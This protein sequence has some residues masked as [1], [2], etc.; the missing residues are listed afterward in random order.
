VS[1]PENI[2]LL[3]DD[4][5]Q[6]LGALCSEL[7][8]DGYTVIVAIDGASALERLELVSPDA[9]LMDAL[10]PG[11]D[12]FETCRR[13]KSDPA[14][15]HVPVIFM[16]GLSETS[17]IVKG[18]DAGGVDYVVKPVRAQ[19]VMVR[20]ATHVR[21]ARAVRMARESI[22]IGG[23]GMLMVDARQRLAWQSPQAV[24]WLADFLP[25]KSPED[26]MRWL[27][28]ASQ[29]EDE[30]MPIDKGDQ[31]LVAK[32]VGTVGLGEVMWLLSVRKSDAPAPSR[33]ASAA[34]TPREVEVLSWVS[35]GKTNRDVAEILGMS[36]RTVNKHLEHV[37]EKLGVETR[38]AAAA[39]ASI[40]FSSS[41]PPDK[42]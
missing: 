42:R 27:H 30:A 7:E 35:K 33:L 10:M 40:A 41:P 28:A 34:L 22:D 12:G 37:F 26:Q 36:P 2:I 5:P 21:N 18:F 19:E 39:L 31:T 38:S 15:A 20:L 3:V 8:A 32:R 24:R 16:T 9:I 4:A 23:L 13:I 29:A 6:S 11:M 25:G 17:Q 1:S 14:W